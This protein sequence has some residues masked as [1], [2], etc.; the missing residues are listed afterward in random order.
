MTYNINN[1]SITDN[2]LLQS[3][4]IHGTPCYIYDLRWIS[5]Q[6]K[7]LKKI[8]PDGSELCYSV[9][10][11]P[12]CEIINI[13]NN[14]GSHFDAASVNEIELLI[15]SGVEPNK[16]YYIAPG[17][18]RSDIRGAIKNNIKA[19]VID[20]PKELHK[21][22]EASENMG[23]PQEVMFRLNPGERSYG[24]LSMAGATQFG[25]SKEEIVVCWKELRNRY[26]FIKCIGLQCYQGT[27]ILD[28]K[29]LISEFGKVLN[30]FSDITGVLNE[31]PLLLD[32]GGGF[33]S[34]FSMEEHPLDLMELKAGLTAVVSPHSRKFQNSQYIFESGRYIVGGGGIFL[35]RIRDVKEL[36]N[37]K[38]VIIDGGIHCFGGLGRTNAFR[39][40]P[41]RILRSK[42]TRVESVTLCGPSC[43]PLDVIAHNVKLPSPKEGDLL[44]IYNAGAYQQS[45]SPGRFLSF[46]F[47]TEVCLL[48][49]EAKKL[50]LPNLE[51][52]SCSI[53][54]AE[55]KDTQRIIAFFKAYLH[56]NNPAIYSQEFLCNYGLSGAIKRQSVIVA[57]ERD[58]IV[59]ACRYYRRKNGDISLYQFA[60]REDSRGRHLLIHM[61]KTLGNVCV[62]SKCP[63][64]IG[65]N[66]Y[67]KKTGW[68]L[69]K[70]DG[71]YC[72]WIMSFRT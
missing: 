17:K 28:E 20:S 70:N 38:Y 36:S 32:I 23:K 33:G 43:T 59:A 72:H 40:P 41:I 18:S 69:E 57:Y 42:E 54:I 24:S 61:L 52:C 62:H 58:S 71:E 26:P 31:V 65:F 63:A 19:I 9:K 4:E 2:D 64:E 55:Q 67:Y 39:P 46:G 48:T 27:N 1:L 14:I 21:I 5:N 45:A 7:E 34:P 35:T 16:I 56:D 29:L 8:L 68:H 30:D 25:M 6:W 13:L 60:I 47:P 22:I 49:N 11:N 44:A 50:G 51:E 53:G 66:N 3:A 10:A 37:R 15:S 12:N